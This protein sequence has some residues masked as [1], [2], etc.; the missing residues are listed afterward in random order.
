MIISKIEIVFTL[1]SF[2]KNENEV[3]NGV[4]NLKLKKIIYLRNLNEDISSEPDS[5]SFDNEDSEDSEES[6]VSLNGNKNSDYQLIGFGNFNEKVNEVLKWDMFMIIN[7]YTK[8]DFIFH[9]VKISPSSF[10]NLEENNPVECKKSNNKDFFYEFSCKTNTKIKETNS[11]VSAN[12]DFKIIGTNGEEFIND[13]MFATEKTKKEMENIQEQK[14]KDY[15]ILNGTITNNDNNTG[16]FIEGDIVSL[17]SLKIPLEEK[18]E[19]KF[20]F[21]NISTNCKVILVKNNI[22]YQLECKPSSDLKA[23]IYLSCTDIDNSKLCLYIEG[24]DYININLKNNDD[25]I[26]IVK[27]SSSRLSPGAIAGIVIGGTVIL[28]IV[29]TLIIIFCCNKKPVEPQNFNHNYESS[30]SIEDFNH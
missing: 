29:M 30:T 4:N 5:S 20:E 14:F 1:N 23:Y 10:R 19:I 24:N 25:N 12:K 16:F 13:K 15:L 8:P 26:I 18:D 22:H 27:K 3:K 21:D 28:F 11:K 9:S 2:N 7:A 17:K 6:T